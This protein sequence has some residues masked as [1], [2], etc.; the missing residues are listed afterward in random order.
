MIEVEMLPRLSLKMEVY[1]LFS[2]GGAAH[3]WGENRGWCLVAAQW[4]G[5]GAKV[6]N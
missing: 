4:L 3:G 6:A 2:I 1:R 5:G